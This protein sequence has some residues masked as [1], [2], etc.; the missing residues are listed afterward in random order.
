MCLL[1]SRSQGIF[2]FLRVGARQQ[3]RKGCAHFVV[4]HRG[5]SGCPQCV[6]PCELPRKDEEKERWQDVSSHCPCTIHALCFLLLCGS[7]SKIQEAKE[8][9]FFVDQTMTTYSP[10]L[11]PYHLPLSSRVGLVFVFSQGVAVAFCPSP[12]FSSEKHQSR[13]EWRVAAALPR[14]T[15]RCAR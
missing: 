3:S 11:P 5:G 8:G 4:F 13:E 7:K 9:V 6:L 15:R 1:S 12:E 2:F 14:C 10:L